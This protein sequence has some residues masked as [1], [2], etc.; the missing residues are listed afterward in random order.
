MNCTPRDSR[1]RL[2]LLGLCGLLV[3][4]VLGIR[5]FWIQVVEGEKYATI[6]RDQ[7]IERVR[8]LPHRGRILDRHDVP[9]AY[10]VDNPVLVAEPARLG[11]PAQRRQTTRA[12]ARYLETSAAD[13]DRKIA[14]AGRRPVVLNRQPTPLPSELLDSLDFQGITSNR[15]PKR[16]YPLGPAAAHVTGFVGVDQEGIEGTEKAYDRELQGS[17]GWA[18]F[19]RDAHGGRHPFGWD[20]PPVPGNDLALTIDSYLQQITVS[21]LEEAV[22]RTNARGGWA[23]VIAPKTGDILAF[24]NAPGYDP[25]YH[26]RSPQANYR[27]HILSDRI[28]PGSTIKAITVAAALEDGAFSPA[29]PI[30]C[31][32][33]RWMCMGKP[34]TDHEAFGTL[35][36]LDT[37][38]HSSNIGMAQVGL[39][40]GKERMY[41][42]LKSFGFG[43]KTGLG[44]PGE[45]A[46][47]LKR[48]DN[49]GNRTP[50]VVAYGYELQVTALQLAMAYGALANDGVLMKPRLVRAVLS[51]DGHV[52]RETRPEVVRRVVS[53]R[54]ARRL[55]EFMGKVVESGTGKQ[56]AVDWCVVGGKTGTARK[57]D[58]KTKQYVA[59]HYASFVGVAPLDDPC[60]LCYVVIDEPVGNVYGGSTA[61]PVFREILDAAAKS[62]R[63]LILPALDT[64]HAAPAA[65]R[66][67]RAPGTLR[68]TLGGD[69]LTVPAPDDTLLAA[70][71]P[72]APPAPDLI[73]LSLRQALRRLCN[74]GLTGQVS[75]AGVVVRQVP[76][77]G[78]RPAAWQNGRVLVYLGDRRELAAR[79]SDGGE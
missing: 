26:G 67:R 44:L 17:P 16:V 56:A 5:L 23:I 15:E 2:K 77:P 49:W 39:K 37:F 48:L 42:Y 10:T 59:K 20:R 32:G 30:N 65:P 69:T 71:D 36:L 41:H 21:R 76:G 66:A 8:L 43:Q 28:E 25:T 52:L 54:T 45:V 1:S 78:E 73:G 34:I 19:R 14:R 9:L 61:A 75:G 11:S 24:A 70:V 55:L 27:N 12:L 58:P 50:A 62:P 29:T 74:A 6:S 64:I 3:F 57:V 4:A 7:H 51:P 46:G 13:L 40:V 79:E 33:G 35:T 53:S 68:A 72:A 22:A 63:P 18:T 47:T 38:V 31:M 60:L